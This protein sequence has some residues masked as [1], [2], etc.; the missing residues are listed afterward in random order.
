MT[1]YVIEADF[2]IRDGGREHHMVVADSDMGNAVMLAFGYE[3][4]LTP[5]DGTIERVS[6]G[7]VGTD[8]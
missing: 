1:M 4:P 5:A 8:G 2:R 3:Q 7:K 6:V